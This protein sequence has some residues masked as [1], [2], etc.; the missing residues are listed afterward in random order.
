MIFNRAEMEEREQ[1]S[2]APYAM[3]SS[4]S[5]GREY[6]E[7]EAS[8]RTAF[9][10]DRDRILHTT[11]F[12]RLEYKT[13]VFV[14]HEG[15]YFRTRLTHTLEVAQIGRSL[16]RILGANE[17]LVEAVCLVHDIGHPPFGHSGEATLA[18]LMK[19]HGGFDHNRQALRIVT[20][21]EKRYVDF[22]GLNLTY[23]V[24][25]GIVKHETEYDISSAEDYEPDKRGDLEAQIANGSD[26][27]AYTAHDLDDGLYAGLLVPSQIRGLALWDI[28]CEQL[29]LR[30]DNFDELARHRLIRRLIGILVRD[31]YESTAER[32]DNATP[33]SVKALQKLPYNVVGH[34]KSMAKMVRE[35]KDFLYQN[36][37]RH[38]RVVRMAQKAERIISSIFEAYMSDPAQLPDT[39]QD[40][41]KAGDDTKARVICDYIAGMTDR[42]ASQE[43]QKLFDPFT[44]P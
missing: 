39:V 25:E 44:R 32:L 38:Y 21:L 35:L 10:R 42:Y 24:R 15:D 13:Q 41:L 9:Q 29:D 22:S 2:L 30:D 5:K 19:K 3:K 26:E 34:S 31:Y 8:D 4:D 17:D 18:S 12:R 28:T 37:Y 20:R 16:A 6:P 14:N 36:M 23:E 1:I 7:D 33:K 40:R 43:Y 27:I 11:A